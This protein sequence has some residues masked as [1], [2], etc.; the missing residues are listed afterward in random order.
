MPGC[1]MAYRRRRV[2]IVDDDIG[3]RGFLTLALEDE[4]YEVRGATDGREALAVLGE[5]RAD[6]IVLDLMMPEMDGRSF[7]TEQH[8]VAGYADIPVLIV[9]ALHDLANQARGLSAVAVYEK[10][11]ALDEFLD[12][13]RSLTELKQT[14]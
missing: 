9:S 11:L 1:D 14:S 7:L 5:W 4:G 8:R 3:V 10:P 13:V 12:A 6:L 2:L